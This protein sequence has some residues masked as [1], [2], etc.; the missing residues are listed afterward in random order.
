M[1]GGIGVRRGCP[2]AEGT[3]LSCPPHPLGYTGSVQEGTAQ[4]MSPRRRESLG[5]DFPGGP[6][7]KT[8]CFHCRRRRFDPWSG[9]QDPTCQA[10]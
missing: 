7:V 2:R 9:N 5:W 1:L 3:V 8:L 6:V 10:A 4:A